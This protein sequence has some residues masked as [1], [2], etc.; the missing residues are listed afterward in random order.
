MKIALCSKGNFSLEKGFTKN[1]IELAESLQKLGWETILVDKNKLGIPVGNKYNATTHSHA[2]KNYLIENYYE[3]DVVLYEYDTLPFDRSEFNK[4]TLFIARPAILAYHESVIKLKYNFK[5]KISSLIRDVRNKLN[6][7]K[8]DHKTLFKHLNYCLTQADLI[9]VQNKKDQELLISHGF[10]KHKIIIVPN[11]ISRDRIVKFGS[12]SKQYQKPFSVAFVGTFDFRKGAMDFPI[13]FK[14]IK[15]KFP[16]L[17]LKLLGTRGMF[18]SSQQV[19][20]FF[21]KKFHCDI[22]VIPAFK[23]EELPDF[24]KECHIGIFPSYLESFGFGALEMMCA[25]LPVV[26]YDSPGPSDFILPDLLVPTG[27]VKQFSEKVITSLEDKNLLEH[28]GQKARQTV[29]NSYCWDDIAKDVDC[30]YKNHLEKLR[31]RPVLS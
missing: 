21:P 26:A 20:D 15:E 3:F 1:R 25:G 7:S 11:G 8:K 13:I 31:R 22:E 23:A 14:R 17:K 18:F 30:Q 10:S 24:L 6:G 5:T 29:I 9:Q 27:D 12:N 2:L 19:L 28:N 16:D 4:H